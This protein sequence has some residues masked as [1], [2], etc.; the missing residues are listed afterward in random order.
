MTD[1]AS[2]SESRLAQFPVTFFASVMGLAGLTL[3]LHRAELAFGWPHAA[4]LAALVLTIA[5]FVVIAGFF[6]L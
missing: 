2:P 1:A 6:G 4:S 5:D 3:A